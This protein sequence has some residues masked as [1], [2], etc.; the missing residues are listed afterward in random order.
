M[1]VWQGV[2]IDSLKF[3]LGPPCLTLLCLAGGP[4]AGWRA[5]GH[6][7][8][9]WTALCLCLPPPASRLPPLASRLPPPASRLP[10]LASRLPPPASRLPP[11]ASSLPPLDSCLW[12]PASGLPPPASRLWPP[13]SRVYDCRYFQMIPRFSRILFGFIRILPKMFFFSTG[14]NMYGWPAKFGKT[15]PDKSVHP[16]VCMRCTSGPFRVTV[17]GQRSAAHREFVTK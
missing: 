10:P 15:R 14:F 16:W 6:P 8:P 2:A 12:P 9:L 17:Y 11:L 5:F 7:L 1:D 4:P 3:H 13:A